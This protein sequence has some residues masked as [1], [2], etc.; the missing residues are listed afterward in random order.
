M[1]TDRTDVTIVSQYNPVRAWLYRPGGDARPERSPAIVMAHG[2]SG[3]KELGLDRYAEVFAEAGF[4]VCVFDHPNFGGSGGT[5]RQEVDADRQLAA[6]RDVLSWVGGL[7]DVDPDRL[8]VWGTSFSGG[9]ALVL[10]ATE[11]RVRA[12]VAQVPYICP[13]LDEPPPDLISVL[14][15]DEEQRRNGADPIMIPV[16][17]NDTAGFGALSPDPDA[18]EWFTARAATAPAWRNEVTLRSLARLFLYRPIDFAPQ[19]VAPLLLIAASDDVLSPLSFV[20]SAA[21]RISAP[22]DLLELDGGHFDVYGELFGVSAQ[23]ALGWFERWL[24]PTGV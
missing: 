6:Y 24:G 14:Q 5:P 8:G 13:P 19:V 9:H 22:H 7:D 12:A 3:V 18:H 1:T 4:V 17:T 20:R 10:A 15:Y 23:A 21:Q 11:P 16:T 2:F